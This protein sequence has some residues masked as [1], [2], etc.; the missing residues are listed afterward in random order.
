[1]F[2]PVN[3]AS[4]RIV[5]VNEIAVARANVIINGTM[6]KSDKDG[7]VEIVQNML[8]GSYTVVAGCVVSKTQLAV[9]LSS[10]L[11]EQ[12]IKIDPTV[13]PTLTVQLMLLGSPVVQK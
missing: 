8:H 12:K 3:T 2:E 4:L 6:Y 11:V 5:D 9:N 13:A 1:M 7:N 10:D